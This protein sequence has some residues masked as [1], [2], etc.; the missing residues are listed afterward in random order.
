MVGLNTVFKQVFSEG[1]KDQGFQKIKGRQPYLV[2]V[3]EGG[4]IIHV[5]SCRNLW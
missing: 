2:R 1:L 3:V 5:I 4:E